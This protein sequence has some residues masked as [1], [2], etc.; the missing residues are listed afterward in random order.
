MSATFQID[1]AAVAIC[2]NQQYPHCKNAAELYT[3]TRGL[4]RLS[5]E[6]AEQAEYVFAVYQGVIKEVYQAD[7][8]I[9]ATKAFREFWV[10][11]LRGQGR[12]ISPAEHDGRYEFIGRLAPEPVRQKYIGHP[13]QFRH[14]GNPILYFNC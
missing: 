9:P 13:L 2:I 4:W 5:K 12:S 6:R 14:A 8:W 3:C 1:V 7:Q 11:R 10:N